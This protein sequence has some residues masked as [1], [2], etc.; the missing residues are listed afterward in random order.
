M[1]I[2]LLTCLQ[3]HSLSVSPAGAEGESRRFYIWQSQEA[4]SCK[5]KPLTIAR[6]SEIQTDLVLDLVLLM[7]L[8]KMDADRLRVLHGQLQLQEEQQQQ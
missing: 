5:K 2:Y 4:H 6:D 3:A 8:L 7:V 1:T